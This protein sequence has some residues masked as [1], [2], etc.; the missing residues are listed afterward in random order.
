MNNPT[1][2]WRHKKIAEITSLER[3][4]EIESKKKR[5]AEIAIA[6][7]KEHINRLKTAP[8]LPI[9]LFTTLKKDY[10][11]PLGIDAWD[12]QL[13]YYLPDLEKTY[14]EQR[15]A[16]FL[17]RE[18]KTFLL[19]DTLDLRKAFKKRRFGKDNLSGISGNSVFG[20][21]LIMHS[22]RVPAQKRWNIFT[23]TVS[24]LKNTIDHLF[25]YENI[26]SWA[27][28]RERLTDYYLPK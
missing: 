7:L 19:P 22:V 17:D 11:A 18:C 6:N 24:D 4:L 9:L 13:F 12:Y 14:I 1:P 10:A 5:E 20:A 8:A 25:A 16:K 15:A 27:Q 21:E 3:K 26:E 23:H 28:L 2:A